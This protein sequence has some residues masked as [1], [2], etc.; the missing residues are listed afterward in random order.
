M[1]NTYHTLS[2]QQK[3]VRGEGLLIG[4]AIDLKKD[5]LGK[6]HLHTAT[7][8]KKCCTQQT[9]ISSVWLAPQPN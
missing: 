3:R 9:L 5:S 7:Y 6:G 2:R 8:V 4:W 1:L